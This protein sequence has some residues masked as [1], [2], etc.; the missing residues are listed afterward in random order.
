MIVAVCA[1]RGE[2]LMLVPKP[3]QVRDKMGWDN[4]IQRY[5]FNIT[6]LM[7]FSVMTGFLRSLKCY[8]AHS[9]YLVLITVMQ[10]PSVLTTQRLFAPSEFI[11]EE[12]IRSHGCSLM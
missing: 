4:M 8:N 9:F 2:Q 5:F 10:D 7:S 1:T 3:V 12:A 11:S 6:V